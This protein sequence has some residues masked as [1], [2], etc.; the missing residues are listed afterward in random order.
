VRVNVSPPS[1]EQ[2]S[3]CVVD[4]TEHTH[5]RLADLLNESTDLLKGPQHCLFVT[6][7]DMHGFWAA[8][9]TNIRDDNAFFFTFTYC[10]YHL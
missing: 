6:I 9:V 5:S 2:G 1:R 8:D 10:Y 3:A 4:V 7:I